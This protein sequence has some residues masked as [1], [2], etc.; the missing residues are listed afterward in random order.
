LR[1]HRAPPGCARQPASRS[2]SP[3]TPGHSGADRIST[4]RR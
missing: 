2:S 4:G 1:D 3:G